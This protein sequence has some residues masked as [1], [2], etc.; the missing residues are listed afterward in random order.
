MLGWVS[1]HAGNLGAEGNRICLA[2]GP[3]L[4]LWGDRRGN[5]AVVIALSAF[6]IIAAVGAGIDISR[7]AK[8]KAALQN[9]ADAAALA[10]AAQYSSPGQST[11]AQNNAQSYFDKYALGGDIMSASRTVTPAQS[12]STS[13]SSTS[14]SSSSSQAVTVNATATLKTT[15]GGLVGL[16]TMTVNATAVAG[17]V[18]TTT[19]PNPTPPTPLPQTPVV[20]L[21]TGGGSPSQLLSPS[22]SKST[23]ADW[24]SVY[25]YGVPLG[26][27]GQYDYTSFPS[28]SQFYEIGSNCSGAV[29]IQWTSNSACNGQFGAT[30]RSMSYTL[31]A[32][33]PIALMFVNMNNGMFPSGGAG[34]YGP[35]QYGSKPGYFQV[36]T[37]ANMALGQSPSQI[38]DNSVNIIRG[39]TGYQ[40][41][42]TATHYS[43][44]NNATLSNCAVQIV[45]VTDVKNPPTQPPYPGV[46]LSATD[47][48]SGYKYAN[49]SCNQIAGRTFMYWWND[50]GASRDDFDYKNLYFTLTCSNTTTN[51]DAG[52]IGKD[53]GVTGQ[54]PLTTSTTTTYQSSTSTSTPKLIQ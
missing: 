12:N 5:V 20:Q 26:G 52:T 18:T 50:M 27:N 1:K 45:L 44:V 47:A 29:D 23:A 15:F 17:T 8:A 36:M 53:Q 28:L 37:T 39:L 43:D 16:S 25:L 46:C 33:Q 7:M 51:P 2:A 41:S 6:P 22:P 54:V 40:L 24:N 9:A 32:D 38:T 35:N 14:S 30:V 34:G 42:Q 21:G 10:G 31:P 49:L 48:R 3:R 11:V 4:R 13:S 19:T